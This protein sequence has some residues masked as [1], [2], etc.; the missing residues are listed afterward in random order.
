[1]DRTSGK[2]DIRLKFGIVDVVPGQEKIELLINF[3]II[4]TKLNW[5]TQ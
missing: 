4:L 5:I 2:R 3:Y 1:M